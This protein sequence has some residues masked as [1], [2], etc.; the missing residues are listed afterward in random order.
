MKKT[1]ELLK[2]RLSR[3]ARNLNGFVWQKP[4]DQAS[5]IRAFIIKQVRIL[6]LA[7]QNALRNK[8][9]TLAPALTFYSVL[10]IIPAAALAIGIA[11]GFGLERYLE[12]QLR[13]ALAGREEVLVWVMDLTSTFFGQVDGL[14]IALTGL[15]ILLYTILMLLTMVEKI[16]NQ[17]WQVSHGRTLFHRLRDYFAIILI[18]PLL[19][20]AS[21]AVT[22]FFSTRAQLFEGSLLNPV[23]VLI[24]RLMPYLLI[25]FLFILLYK[26]MPNTRVHLYPAAV[27]G[28]IAGTVFQMIQWVYLTFQIGAAGLGIIYGSFAALP[29]LL[30]WMQI[31][32][33]VVLFGAELTHAAQNI[34]RYSYGPRPEEISSYNRKL[35][36]LY[37]LHWL[38]KSYQDTPTP[39]T[40]HQ[41]SVELKIP[42]LLVEDI[43]KGLCEACLLSTVPAAAGG[44]GDREALTYR[45]AADADTVSIAEALKQLELQGSGSYLPE[46][47]PVLEKLISSVEKLG[48]AIDKS[49]ANKL[50]VD[51]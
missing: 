30:I 40:A 8:I 49:E 44:G 47:S 24:L 51:L 39:L 10:S 22:V 11:K 7:I 6:Y 29:L 23:L 20:I 35:I 38:L 33:A 15:G 9:Y 42:E 19:L 50:L 25:W 14:F 31:S 1:I 48:K 36:S 26:I 37:I 12:Q 21:G 4:I 5:P 41:V 27:N 43:L 46:P 3:A 16:F 18:G 13:I 34:D 45:P 32:W 28:I 17:V 2:N